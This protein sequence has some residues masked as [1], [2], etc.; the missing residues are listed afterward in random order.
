MFNLFIV[1]Q[2]RSVGDM[3]VDVLA[4]EFF[5]MI[6]DE[7]KV[8]LLNFDCSFLEDMVIEAVED[9]CY[10]GS[11]STLEDGHGGGGG[12]G[13]GGE[14]D[15]YR[16]G[17]KNETREGA[18]ASVVRTFFVTPLEAALHGIR[19]VCRVIGPAFSC[20]MIFY[21]PYCLGMPEG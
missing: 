19:M 4:L 12:G 14:D 6:D 7:F 2:D 9:G 5:T 16:D 15:D 21:G 1:F 3:I 20:V 17:N 8:A 18:C 10:V 13:G 11:A